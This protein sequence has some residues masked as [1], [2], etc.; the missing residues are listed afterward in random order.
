[1]YVCKYYIYVVFSYTY[2]NIFTYYVYIYMY[3]YI[4][5]CY[6]F[7]YIYSPKTEI[8]VQQLLVLSSQPSVVFSSSRGVS[9]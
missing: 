6:V 2:I 3:T 4:Y 5:V 1:M 8:L 9:E 7:I